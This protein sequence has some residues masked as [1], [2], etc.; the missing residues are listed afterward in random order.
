MFVINRTKDILLVE[1]PFDEKFDAEALHILLIQ[2]FYA[3]AN[4]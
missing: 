1:I 2:I 4:T 3:K